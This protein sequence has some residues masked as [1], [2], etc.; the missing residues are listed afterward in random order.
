MGLAKRRLE[1]IESRGASFIG[2]KFVCADCVGDRALKDFIQENGTAKNCDYCGEVNPVVLVDDV[3]E[4]I[5][6]GIKTEYDEPGNGLGWASEEG[7]WLG[8]TIDTWDILEDLEVAENESLFND[9]REAITAEIWCGSE[10]YGLTHHKRLLYGWQAFG[11]ILKH[12]RRFFAVGKP[13]EI[14]DPYDELASPEEV[15][16]AISDALRELDLIRRLAQNTDIF[17]A[18]LHKSGEILS[19]VEQLGPPP[20]KLASANRMNGQGIPIC[21]GAFDA[22]TAL[23]EVGFPNQKNDATVAIFTTMLELDVVDLTKLPKVPSIFDEDLRHLRPLVRFLHDFVE[24]L[25]KPIDPADAAVEYLP[26]QMVTEHFRY[27]MDLEI[28]GVIYPSSR[29]S[30][31]SS[32]ALFFDNDEC[33]PQVESWKA[34]TQSLNFRADSVKVFSGSGQ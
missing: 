11:E 7:G 22:E 15:L 34:K 30:G 4:K 33:N 9:I 19:T 20:K 24:D 18:R 28:K 17:R 1:E 25:I 2:D 16:S 26:T 31:G 10:F 23:A 14:D 8:S 21:Y 12:E 29:R 3:V 27:G 13:K 5:V 32:C 6:E